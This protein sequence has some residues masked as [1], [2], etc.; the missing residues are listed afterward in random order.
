MNKKTVS[1]LIFWC[2]GL[3]AL[4]VTLDLAGSGRLYDSV[5]RLHVLA[6][7]DSREDQA[8]K[9]AVRDE[10]L[11]YCEKNFALKDRESAERELASDLDGIRDAAVTKLRELGHEENVTVTLAREEYPTRRY[12]EISLPGGTYTSL[13]VSIGAAK[14]KNWWCV[15][16]P[17]FCLDSAADTESALLHAGMAEE[18][19]KTVTL[20][21]TKY[22]IRF[23]ILEW[24]NALRQKNKGKI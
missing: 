1:A 4:T 17:P 16:F 18:D 9:L 22:E 13:K 8:V 20:D 2:L 11:S 15:L 24:F 5:I 21:G 14:G 7:S 19:V 23:H 6:D 3:I 10:V 12:E